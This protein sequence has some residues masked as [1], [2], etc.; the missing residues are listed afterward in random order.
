MNLTLI[1]SL[2]SAVAAGLAG[3]GLAWRLQ[4]ATIDQMELEQANERI[5]LQRA[6][7]ATMERQQSAVVTAQNAAAE[8]RRAL[9]IVR[10][11]GDAAL[12][13]LRD[14]TAAA[15]RAASESLDACNRVVTTHG[16]ILAECSSTL[17]KVA[18]DA[19][20]C[21]SDTKTLIEAWPD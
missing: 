4:T 13:G 12:V 20:Q 8:R 11:D 17:Q 16:D 21:I 2:I 5:S 10:R 1:A 18:G 9:A 19:D 6:A 14:A 7:R 3:F 15:M